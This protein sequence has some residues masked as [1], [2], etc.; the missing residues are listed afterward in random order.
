M[1]TYT[2]VAFTNMRSSPILFQDGKTEIE[3]TLHLSAGTVQRLKKYL[4]EERTIYNTFR[5]YMDRN[6]G[7]YKWVPKL[8]IICEYSS[9]TRNL[10]KA[11]S[12]SSTRFSQL[13]LHHVC[14]FKFLRNCVTEKSYHRYKVQKILPWCYIIT[15][16]IY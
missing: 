4:L 2:L 13:L 15:W 11:V 1:F 8:T 12:S 7:E 14:S 6:I 9:H 10:K 3:Q 16:Y 5:K